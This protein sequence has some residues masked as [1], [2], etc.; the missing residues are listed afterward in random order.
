MMQAESDGFAAI[1]AMLDPELSVASLH[2]AWS[3]RLV[4]GYRRVPQRLRAGRLPRLVLDEQDL[5]VSGCSM[6]CVSPEALRDPGLDSR[7]CFPTTTP[8]SRRG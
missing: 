4:R 8:A 6:Q 3:G 5:K 1:A 7:R 2:G